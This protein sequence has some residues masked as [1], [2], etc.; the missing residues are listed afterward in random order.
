MAR[1]LAPGASGAV[2]RSGAGPEKRGRKMKTI[3]QMYP[4]LPEAELSQRR[5]VA[6]ALATELGVDLVEEDIAF[7]H[8][9]SMVCKVVTAETAVEVQNAL[10]VKANYPDGSTRSPWQ[11]TK[12]YLARHRG[13]VRV[14]IETR[15]GGYTYYH[16][17]YGTVEVPAQ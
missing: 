10:P 3:A 9:G 15:H 16:P 13:D 2:S 17:D 4:P 1:G 14:Q 8:G 11:P 6:A 5:Q 7:N 12:V